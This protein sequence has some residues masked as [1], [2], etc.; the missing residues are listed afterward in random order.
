MAP[1][2]YRSTDPVDIDLSAIQHQRGVRLGEST[3]AL[4][5]TFLTALGSLA[6]SAIWVKFEADANAKDIVRLADTDKQLFVL[7][8]QDKTALDVRLRTIEEK[9]DIV[10]GEMRATHQENPRGHP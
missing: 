6:Y 5:V 10:I 9:L 3:L 7:R 2:R 4:V 8:D 1:P